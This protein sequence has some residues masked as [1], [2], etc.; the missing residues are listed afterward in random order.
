[1]EKYLVDAFENAVFLPSICFNKVRILHTRQANLFIPSLSEWNLTRP[2]L[3]CTVMQIILT[4]FNLSTQS[5]QWTYFREGTF[6]QR[7]LSNSHRVIESPFSNLQPNRTKSY[8][9]RS[10][11]RKRNSREFQSTWYAYHHLILIAISDLKLS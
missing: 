10:L 11:L 1:M 4:F 8:L 5:N 7:R 3:F 6:S 9:R 2:H